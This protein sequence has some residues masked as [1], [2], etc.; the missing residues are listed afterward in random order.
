[1]LTSK[2]SQPQVGTLK[3]DLV[4]SI[5]FDMLITKIISIFPVEFAFSSTSASNFCFIELENGRAARADQVTAS[6]TGHIISQ[7]RLSNQPNQ[8]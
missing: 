8:P 4:G 3:P 1:M 7:L 6:G 2:P 5:N